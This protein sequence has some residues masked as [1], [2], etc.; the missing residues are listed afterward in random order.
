MSLFDVIA[1]VRTDMGK[2]ASRR[3]R[4][5]GLVPAIVYGANAEPQCLSLSHNE[6]QKHLAHEA[7]YAH[8]LNLKL[9]GETTK[10]VLRDVH[11]HPGKPVILHMDFQRV[12]AKKPIR[13]QVPL[14]FMGEDD[15][16]GVKEGGMVSHERTE[17]AIDVL[18]GEL[19]EYI[20]VDISA[21]NIGDSLHLSDLKL[22]ASAVLLDLAKG[23]DYDQPI[24]A[25]HEQKRAEEEPE[26]GADE[27]SEDAAEGEADADA[28]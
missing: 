14:H 6:V 18:P 7:F 8:I 27:A 25:I 13:V 1:E 12:D 20:E 24:V 21:L 26:V 22:P 28:E 23:D 15:S 4:R 19:P 3:L 11:R 10:V 2:G 16:P 9:A 17:V 5:A